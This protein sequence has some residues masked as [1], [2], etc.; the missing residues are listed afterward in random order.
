MFQFVYRLFPQQQHVQN[1]IIRNSSE[2]WNVAAEFLCK[3]V[4]K[5]L[6]EKKSNRI[7]VYL[8]VLIILSV[9]FQLYLYE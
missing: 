1:V 5:L 4:S 7:T 3:S 9:K 6:F 8:I 2:F